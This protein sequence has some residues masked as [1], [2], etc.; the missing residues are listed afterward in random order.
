V[1]RGTALAKADLCVSVLTAGVC[2][3]SKL[4]VNEQRWRFAGRQ[5]I[6][7]KSTRLRFSVRVAPHAI[8]WH[9]TTIRLQ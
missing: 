3:G 5:C 6:G 9:T 4:F 7:S 8:I 1:S 2:V